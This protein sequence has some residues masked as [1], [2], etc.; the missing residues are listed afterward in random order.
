M[1]SIKVPLS[2]PYLDE[3][4]ILEVT[5]VL[6]ST[7][8]SLGRK[9]EDFERKFAETIGTKYALAMNSG[10][11]ALHLSVRSLGL[12]EGD[13]VI[14]TPFSFIASA[15]CLLYEG[16]RPVFVDID[17]ES[18]GLSPDKVSKAI[19]EHTKGILPVHVFGQ[20]ALMKDLME[21]AHANQ[22]RVI[23]D[24]CESISARH[25]GRVVGTFGDVAAFGFYPNK[26]LT[27]GEGGMLLTDNQEI[28]HLCKSLRNQGRGDNMSL[29]IHDK[30]GYNYRMSEI[31]AA[32]GLAQLNKLSDILEKRRK[33]AKLYV[34][35]LSEIEGIKLP[36]V[37]AHSENAL[38]V[39]HIRVSAEIRDRTI[40]GLNNRGIQSKAYF[41]PC[42]HLQ[43][44]Y[45][46]RFGYHEGMFPVA[47]RLSK[48]V[49][50]LPFFTSMT[51]GDVMTVKE[52]LVQSLK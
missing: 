15:N 48:E 2:K 31:T 4:E 28:Y 22:L 8:L 14:T 27:T 10:T 13:E 3:E 40:E 17:E 34:E 33:L 32:I 25:H 6:R 47:E 51:H 38:F 11:S 50:I 30:L 35:E 36:Q 19:T 46:D 39:F 24:C 7:Q 1:S 37:S 43:P 23:E 52:A 21:I 9:T 20:P 42:I 49:I 16:V 29:L 12:G 45:R 44:Y 5:R 18:L 41:H 26:Q